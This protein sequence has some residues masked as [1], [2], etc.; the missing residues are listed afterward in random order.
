MSWSI[1]IAR[2]RET[3]IRVHLT[4]FL[5]VAWIAAAQGSAGGLA[6]ALDGAL[7]IMLV[8]VC[9]ALHELGHAAAARRYG[10]RT[11]D[12]TLYPFGGVAS[13]ERMPEKPTQEIV[14]ALA[15][16]LV[17]VVIAAALWVVIGARF[18]LADMTQMMEAQM[19]LMGRLAAVNVVLVVFNLI[20]AFPTDG[21]RVFRALLALR[22]G[23]V[24]ATRIAS[25]VGQAL[26]VAFVFL[27]LLGNPLLALVGVFLFVA[28]TSENRAVAE[29]ALAGGFRV[30]DAMVRRFEALR[31]GARAADAARML[32]ATTQQEFP[33]V[34]D[35][36]RLS[37]MVLRADLVAALKS[38]GDE[39]P[40]ESFMRRDLPIATPD[41]RLDRRLDAMGGTG[42]RVLIVEDAAGVFLGYVSAE[43]L[44][45][46]FM[47]A[48]AR[49]AA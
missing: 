19:S 46:L 16:P 4:F 45:E 8:L 21:G 6:A 35:D 49:R 38:G 26:A 24:R 36:G 32:L 31:P 12:I 42:A 43:N 20:P 30:A 22:L 33:V 37:G 44:M 3:T 39:V 47:V 14:V 28:A 10:I 23:S 17:N 15:G 11:P 48:E 13:L 7:F 2:L 5:L 29:R 41:E 27:G 18:D 9:V 25:G 34:D 40:V 1:N